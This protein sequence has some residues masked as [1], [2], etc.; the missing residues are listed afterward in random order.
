ME[1]INA[2]MA[3]HIDASKFIYVKAG[4]FANK[5]KDNVIKP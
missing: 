4:D 3:K 5:L 2:A 1:E